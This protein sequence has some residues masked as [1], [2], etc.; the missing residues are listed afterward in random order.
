M[1][2]RCKNK[3]LSQKESYSWQRF[4]EKT[5]KETK[6]NFMEA[7]DVAELI[8]KED[9]FIHWLVYPK[10][11]SQKTF[12]G[13]ANQPPVMVNALRQP[14]SWPQILFPSFIIL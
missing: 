3:E 9:S 14:S 10:R 11:K 8:K 5:E 4:Y 6:G 13:E 2:K 7:V 1:S 12:G